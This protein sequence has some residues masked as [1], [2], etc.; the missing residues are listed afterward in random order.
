MLLVPS[1]NGLILSSPIALNGVS[2]L[3]VD[4][5]FSLSFTDEEIALDI[6]LFPIPLIAYF[7]FRES[8]I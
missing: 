7:I 5:A 1:T 2:W 3:S 4:V 8:L 6:V